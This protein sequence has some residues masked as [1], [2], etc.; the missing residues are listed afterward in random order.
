MLVTAHVRDRPAD[1]KRLLGAQ[2]RA[3]EGVHEDVYAERRA[4]VK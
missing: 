3:R 4:Y 2:E 1:L